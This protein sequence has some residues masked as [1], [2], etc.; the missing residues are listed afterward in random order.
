MASRRRLLFRYSASVHDCYSH[1]MLMV[2]WAVSFRNQD[3]CKKNTFVIALLDSVSDGLVPAN[4]TY[5]ISRCFQR[6]VC[7]GDCKIVH[8]QLR[9]L[10]QHFSS[11]F[12]L[13]FIE[14]SHSPLWSKSSWL[15]SFSVI[16]AVVWGDL[17]LLGNNVSCYLIIPP[18]YDLTGF[19]SGQHIIESKSW[20]LA[21]L[22]F[23]LSAIIHFIFSTAVGALSLR[24]RTEWVNVGSEWPWGDFIF[25]GTAEMEREKKW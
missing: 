3:K 12:S 11:L 8:L 7:C 16:S 1:Q 22:Y 9:V 14:N 5:I 19:G 18:T 23:L 4:W 13:T 6:Q 10:I 2:H 24:F 20:F 15:A 21:K 25:P 17:L